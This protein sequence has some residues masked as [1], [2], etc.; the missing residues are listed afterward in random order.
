MCTSTYH[1]IV[2]LYDS[3]CRIGFGFFYIPETLREDEVDG[4]GKGRLERIT[5]D[6]MD[7][8][9]VGV[10]R[11]E[12]RGA[13]E[14][15][16]PDFD[17]ALDEPLLLRECVDDTEEGISIHISTKARAFAVWAAR[18]ASPS[19]TPGEMAAVSLLYSMP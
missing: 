19:A 13:V 17:D 14:D 15:G 18:S 3:Y 5:Q 2:D 16:R 8:S 1:T 4:G 11:A 12:H 7:V 10:L 9:D 6:T